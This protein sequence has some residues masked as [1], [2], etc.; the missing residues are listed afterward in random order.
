VGRPP[1]DTGPAGFLRD[2]I[3]RMSLRSVIR[4]D[5]EGRAARMPLPMRLMAMLD[6][7]SKGR[8]RRSG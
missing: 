1:P 6:R 7:R 4:A 3:V 5:D 8:G 2:A